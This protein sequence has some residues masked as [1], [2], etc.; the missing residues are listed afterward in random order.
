MGTAV[1]GVSRAES[2]TESEIAAPVIE[3]C[4][5][6]IGRGKPLPYGSTHV[7][8]LKSETLPRLPPEGAVAEGD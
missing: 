5:N 4:T 8:C 1:G 2:R 7:V 3:V 6:F